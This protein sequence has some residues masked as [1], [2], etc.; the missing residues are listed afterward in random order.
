MGAVVENAMAEGI[1]KCGL[2]LRYYGCSDNTGGRRMELDFILESGRDIIA[3]EVKSGR[4]RT[5]PSLRKVRSVFDQVNRRVILS[6]SNVYTDGEGVEHYPLFAA[7]FADRLFD[8]WDG[9]A[10]MAYNGM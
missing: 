7:C 1:R 2:R 3:V 4:D 10:F 6:R 9:P 8:D 5:A